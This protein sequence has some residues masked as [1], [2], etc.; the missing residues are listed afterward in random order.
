MFDTLGTQTWPAHKACR[1][2]ATVRNASLIFSEEDY[3]SGDGMQTSIFGP[4]FWTA[5][6]LVSFNYPVTP[7]VEQKKQY[8]EWFNATGNVL[9]CVHCRN[10]FQRNVTDAKEKMKRLLEIEDCFA[11]RHNFSR[12]C[13]ELHEVVNRAT[14]KESNHTF[15]CVRDLYEG[16]RACCH[17]NPQ[18]SPAK[19]GIEMGCV[20]ERH[21]GTGGKCVL[22]IVPTS[23]AGEGLSVSTDCRGSNSR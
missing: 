22:Q 21:R 10:N 20:K 2:L 16:F 11:S 13:F 5:I 14:G 12:F 3:R 9:P 4:V 18:N 7:S 19:P 17:T 8:E 23:H 15:D 6:H 1:A